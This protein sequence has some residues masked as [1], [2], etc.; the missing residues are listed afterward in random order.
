MTDSRRAPV[1]ADVGHVQPAVVEGDRLDVDGVDPELYRPLGPAILIQPVGD[2]GVAGV[3]DGP[4]PLGVGV[5]GQSGRLG[6][7]VV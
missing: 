4:V 7:P 3:V 5:G 1:V 6:D 2:A